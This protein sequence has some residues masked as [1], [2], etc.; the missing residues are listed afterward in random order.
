MKISEALPGFSSY[1]E[2]STRLSKIT[3]TRYLYELKVFAEHTDDCD[4]GQFTPALLLDWNTSL[5][6]SGMVYNTNSLKHAALKKFLNY[7]DEFAENEHAGRLLRAL[8]RLQV[9]GDKKPVRKTHPLTEHQMNLLLVFATIRPLTGGRDV[10][11]IHFL[12]DTGVRRAELAGLLL[13]AVDLEQRL[14][15][16]TG[17]GDKTRTVI[18]GDDCQKALGWW[19]EDRERWPHRAGVNNFF[20]KVNGYPMTPDAVSSA[21]HAIAKEAR[22]GGQVWTDLFRHNRVTELLNRGMAVQDV[23]QLAGHSNINT[24]MGYLHANMEHLKSSYDQATGKRED[25]G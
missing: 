3:K 8:N 23:A 4:L 15:T 24:T 20:L 1:L 12:W 11:I 7:L 14:A 9:P 17:K 22:L 21:I 2:S 5:Q 6:Q 13:D 25:P 18:F 19:L 10:A 16:V